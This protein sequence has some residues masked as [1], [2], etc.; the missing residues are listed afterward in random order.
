MV[1]F[2]F[3]V[4][5]HNDA[6]LAE[7]MC[8]EFHKAMSAIPCSQSGNQ[9]V[10]LIFVNDG[11]RRENFET[12]RNVAQRFNFVRVIDLSRNFGQHIALSCGYRFARGTYV[13]MFNV[14]MQDPPDQIPVLLDAMKR[15]D[16]DIVIGIRDARIGGLAEKLTSKMFGCLLNLLTGRSVPLN[17]A[18]LRIMN[19]RF[20][21]A[22]N[23]LN[24]HHR[25]LP[26][27]ESWL[28]FR[29]AYCPIRHQARA[30]G[31]SSYTFRKRL[32]M[33]IDSIISFSD[34]PLRSG[35]LLGG[36]IAFLGFLLALIVV[37]QKIFFQDLLP[38]YTSLFSLGMF[39]GGVQIL[40]V[41]LSGLYIGRIL[42]EVQ[43]RP[44]FLIRETIN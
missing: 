43:N 1:A 44:L 8:V 2:S 4:P 15:A 10:E 24:E 33:A 34:L 31:R 14:D 41:G 3:V 20:I 11:G 40:L 36:A 25:Y 18:T 30:D 17:A 23:Q 16:A 26:G 5:I 32:A 12:L 35:I 6:Y 19:R 28:G 9:D 42:R 7:A 38:G 39:L 37:F 29:H 22:Y 27:L 13:G 21:D